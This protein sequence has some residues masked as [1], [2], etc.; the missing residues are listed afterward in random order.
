MTPTRDGGFHSALAPLSPTYT[1]AVAA[2][3]HIT[4]GFVLTARRDG[5][6]GT[7]IVHY[8]RYDWPAA[9]PLLLWAPA[10]V[11]AWH[12]AGMDVEMRV[13]RREVEAAAAAAVAAAAAPGG[14]PKAAPPPLPPPPSGGRAGAALRWVTGL[15]LHF[16]R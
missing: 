3:L 16:A 15:P 5:R 12:G 6:P 2:L 14:T 10:R 13:L 1:G 8:E 9:F 11:A 7:R 4:G